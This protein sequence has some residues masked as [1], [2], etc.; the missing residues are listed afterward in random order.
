[1]AQVINTNVASL[2]AQRNLGVSG[3]M[4]QTSIQRLSSGLRI[5]SA[6]DD[7]AGL[8]ISQRM[9]AQIRGMNQ[10]VR[11]A[12]D[13]ISLSQVAEGAMQE[14]TNILQRMRELSVQ[15]ANSTNNSSDRASIQ[16]EISQLKVNWSVLL[17]ILN[18][19]VKEFSMVLSLAQASRLGRIQTKPSISVSVA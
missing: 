6:K 1:M 8:A 19:M 3:N 7:A 13:G 15:A 16:S 18:S 4:M 17:K 5:N 14:T 9:T 12:N 2:T 11:N 10:A